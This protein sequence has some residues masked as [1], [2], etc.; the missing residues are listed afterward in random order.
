M[1]MHVIEESCSAL[2]EVYNESE[3]LCVQA[4]TDVTRIRSLEA[5]LSEA[6]ATIEQLRATESAMMAEEIDRLEGSSCE[7]IEKG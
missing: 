4:C 7:R 6:K 3:R 5:E 2:R 1:A